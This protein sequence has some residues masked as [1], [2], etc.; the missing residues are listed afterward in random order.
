MVDVTARL[1]FLNNT[2]QTELFLDRFTGL[3]GDDIRRNDMPFP[4]NMM[5]AT[6]AGWFG[7][8]TYKTNGGE[9]STTV[10][11]S[12]VLHGRN[13]GQATMFAVGAQY[14]FQLIKSKSA[15]VN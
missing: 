1:G 10:Q 14:A 4:T 3:S 12:H 7:K 2:F 5:Q 8:Y 13:M 11:V 15:A 9:L 6:S